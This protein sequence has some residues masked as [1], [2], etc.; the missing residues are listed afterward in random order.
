MYFVRCIDLSLSA[1]SQDSNELPVRF[2]GDRIHHDTGLILVPFESQQ[3]VCHY[4]NTHRTYS[5]SAEHQLA[6][7][8]KHIFS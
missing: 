1:Q 5:V 4:Q 8:R 7:N 3:E 2:G 6:Y